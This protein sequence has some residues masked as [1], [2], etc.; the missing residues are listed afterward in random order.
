[1]CLLLLESRGVWLRTATEEK[2]SSDVKPGRTGLVL[3]WVTTFSRCADLYFKS[4]LFL[5]TTILFR[6]Y[7]NL[8]RQ[9]IFLKLYCLRRA[10]IDRVLVLYTGKRVWGSSYSL[11]TGHFTLRAFSA[12]V[13]FGSDDLN[14]SLPRRANSQFASSS[15]GRR[16]RVQRIGDL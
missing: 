6:W 16:T 14:E 5:A 10:V 4:N 8:R 2:T 3:G 15:H 12:L 7:Q 9:C 11:D 1:M 13:S